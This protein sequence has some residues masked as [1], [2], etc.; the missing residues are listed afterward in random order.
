MS[1]AT[2]TPQKPAGEQ[3]GLAK[4]LDAAGWGLFFIWVAITLMLEI[5]LGVGLLGIGLITIA[6]Q[7]ARRYVGLALEGGWVSVGLCFLLAGL[8]ELLAIQVAFFPI[9]LFIVGI[10][11]L[12]AAV[13]GGR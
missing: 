10:G 6:G 2:Q 5:R 8:W 12:A 11:L 7:G 1:Y 3:T 13:R 4:K 9:L